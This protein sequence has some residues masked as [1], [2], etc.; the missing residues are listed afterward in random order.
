MCRLSRPDRPNAGGLPEGAVADVFY[1][2]TAPFDQAE[3]A[4][5]PGE[6]QKVF[7][8]FEVAMFDNL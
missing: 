2:I 6:G 1:F 5:L 4:A 7:D 8:R 3:D